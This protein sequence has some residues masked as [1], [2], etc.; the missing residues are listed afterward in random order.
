[1]RSLEFGAG[2]CHPQAMTDEHPERA[3]D[4]GQQRAEP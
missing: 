1:M 2:A 3:R 4:L